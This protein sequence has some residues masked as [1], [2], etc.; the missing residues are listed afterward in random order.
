MVVWWEW[1]QPMLWEQK[2]LKFESFPVSKKI[3]NRRGRTRVKGPKNTLQITTWPDLCEISPLWQKL[4]VFGN[5][6]K[7]SLVFGKILNLLWQKLWY[8][9]NF[10][11]CKW[12]KIKNNLVILSHCLKSPT[13]RGKIEISGPLLF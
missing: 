12:P 11:W 5:F 3:E 1:V 13:K 7:L 6:S 2:K 4:K 10:H 8:W 9:V